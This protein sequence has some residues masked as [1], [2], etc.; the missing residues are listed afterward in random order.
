MEINKTRK[1]ILTSFDEPTDS[2]LSALMKEVGI[3]AKLKYEKAKKELDKRI[4]LEISQ[5]LEKE[6]TKPK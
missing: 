3:E 6:K 4:E 5:A 1:G 2:E